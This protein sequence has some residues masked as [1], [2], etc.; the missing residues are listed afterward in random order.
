MT[1]SFCLSVHLSVVSAAKWPKQPRSNSLQRPHSITHKGC[2]ICFLPHEKV[3]T[4]E[5]YGCGE[6]LLVALF[7]ALP[8]RDT[9]VDH[10]SRCSVF[11]VDSDRRAHRHSSCRQLADPD[12]A[13]GHFQWR[14][15]VPGTP[16][17]LVSGRR[18]HWPS[19]ASSWNQHFSGLPTHNICT[20]PLQQFTVIVSL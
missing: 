20:V 14:P 6:G 9:S 18:R 17:Q 2:P 7:V 10:W 1:T 13:T 3:S 8:R 15:H 11:G 12:S 5:I 19:S 16:C 4:C